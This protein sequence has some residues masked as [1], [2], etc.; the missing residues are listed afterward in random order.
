MS[1]NSDEGVLT[2]SECLE[3][4]AQVE[5]GRIALS[6]DALPVILPVAF[7]LIDDDVHFWSMRD[8]KLDVAVDNRVVAFE[9]G[10]YEPETGT[11]WSVL[12]QGL[13]QAVH[14]SDSLG[15]SASPFPSP[16]P[17]VISDDQ[18]RM[19]RIQP[20]SVTGQRIRIMSPTATTATAMDIPF[21]HLSSGD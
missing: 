8:S 18:Y 11:G 9:S 12:L 16:S 13:T 7:A 14:E 15:S 10:A 3:L 20:A 17:S 1:A 2:R 5:I 6:M 19:I 4:L 21:L